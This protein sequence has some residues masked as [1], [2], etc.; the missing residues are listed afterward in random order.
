MTVRVVVL[1]PPLAFFLLQH[2]LLEG[3]HQM[4]PVDCALGQHRHLVRVG[5][6]VRVRVRVRVG[7]GLGLG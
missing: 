2:V 7:L 5:V 1:A 6:R 4:G 3:L